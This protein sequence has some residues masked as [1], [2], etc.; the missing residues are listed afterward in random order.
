[1]KS[2]YQLQTHGPVVGFPPISYW[3]NQLTLRGN[4]DLHLLLPDSVL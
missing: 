2:I 3:A 1:M 4:Q